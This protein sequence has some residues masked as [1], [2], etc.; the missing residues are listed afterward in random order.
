MRLAVREPPPLEPPRPR[1]PRPSPRRAAARRPADGGNSG[2]LADD[3]TSHTTALSPALGDGTL[4]S[5]RL[6]ATNHAGL[7]SVVTTASIVIDASPPSDATGLAGCTA[8]NLPPPAPPSVPVSYSTSGSCAA[9]GLSP[10]DEAGCRAASEGSSSVVEYRV[11][12]ADASDAYYI[13][14]RGPGCWRYY[15]SG[16]HY[17]FNPF[18]AVE[19]CTVNHVCVC[20]GAPPVHFQARRRLHPRET[21][22]H[23]MRTPRP[24]S[25]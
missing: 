5:A 6:F 18:D 23:A 16:W 1:R 19:D 4:V 21:P 14:R 11:L 13:A 15:S 12:V 3:T 9:N 8:D 17:L 10:L 25:P 24:P 20:H 2:N 22:P 7:A